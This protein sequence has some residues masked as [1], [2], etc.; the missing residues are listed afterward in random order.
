[1]LKRLL[2]TAA[3]LSNTY[4]A[5][6]ALLVGE[7]DPEFSLSGLGLSP[8]TEGSEMS[9]ELSVK[10][11]MASNVLQSADWKICRI[12]SNPILG[13]IQSEVQE[14]VDL[15]SQWIAEITHLLV[16]LRPAVAHFKTTPQTVE[17]LKTMFWNRIHLLK[18]WYESIIQTIYSPNPS[19]DL[20]KAIHIA[21]TTLRRIQSF[22]ETHDHADLKPFV[23]EYPPYEAVL[24]MY[25][26]SGLHLQL[27]QSFFNIFDPGDEL[28][29]FPEH[30]PEVEIKDSTTDLKPDPEHNLF[31]E[32]LT[33][34]SIEEYLTPPQSDLVFNDNL[35]CNMR[36]LTHQCHKLISWL[37]PDS[38]D[39]LSVDLVQQLFWNRIYL[40]K[41]LME[42]AILN[43]HGFTDTTLNALRFSYP[44][45]VFFI[46]KL[47]SESAEYFQITPASET[48][49]VYEGGLY[50]GRKYFTPG[51]R[52]QILFNGIWD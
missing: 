34:K 44:R 24:N 13:S 40:I 18:A 47:T 14:L 7:I 23:L 6:V 8:Q 42:K 29:V 46:D 9:N 49:R 15:K 51:E 31:R 30:V 27:L 45:L 2:L 48:H 4:G 32:P 52:L 37:S 38:S 12:T 39:D 19:E 33:Q 21:Q 20:D 5:D 26:N 3:L 28:F 25:S 41:A 1:M 10:F 17:A 43:P 16:D 36:I 11:S 22:S 50:Q 35:L